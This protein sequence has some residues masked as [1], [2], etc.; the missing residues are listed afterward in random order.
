MGSGKNAEQTKMYTQIEI[1]PVCES[2]RGGMEGVVNEGGVGWNMYNG[3]EICKI[4]FISPDM[5]NP[6]ATSSSFLV[7]RVCSCDPLALSLLFH[8]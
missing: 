3:C 4:T 8:S 6:M 7:A 1:M 2:A 5:S